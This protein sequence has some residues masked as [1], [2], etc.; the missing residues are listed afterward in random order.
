MTVILTDYEWESYKHERRELEA[1]VKRH[2][3]DFARI[4]NEVHQALD[5]YNEEH[6]L[7]YALL[8]IRGI[9]G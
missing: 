6:D 2:H 9:V 3:R 5:Y 1:E 7:R 4:L 8:M